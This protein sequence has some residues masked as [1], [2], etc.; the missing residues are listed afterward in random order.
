MCSL[1]NLK[2]INDKYYYLP[3]FYIRLISDDYKLLF[4]WL[5]IDIL[6]V[7]TLTTCFSQTKRM[8]WKN[9]NWATIFMMRIK[10]RKS[11]GFFFQLSKK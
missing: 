6:I 5:Y 2:S 10:P 4:V 1:G 7:I 9:Q 3:P 8:N 11:C